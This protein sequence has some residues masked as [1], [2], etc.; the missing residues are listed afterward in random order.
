MKPGKIYIDNN[1]LIRWF[2]HRFYPRK[3][4]RE[5]QIIRFLSEHKEIKKYISLISVAEL[6]HTL[7]Y[8][9]EFQNFKLDLN[10]IRVLIEELQ[11]IVGF[12]IIQKQKVNGMEI[13]GIVISGDVVKFVNVHEHLI[14]CMHIDIA[15]SHELFFITHEKKIGQLKKLYENIMTDDK[16]LKQFK[17]H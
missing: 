11:N 16:L 17:N 3:H 9:K 1:L 8:G 15:K 6:V 12:D 13:N 14:D 7:K 10:Y 4:K 2:L 5:P